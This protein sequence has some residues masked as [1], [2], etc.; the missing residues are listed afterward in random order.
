MKKGIRSHLGFT[1]IE[2]LVVV[3][4][5]G[6]LAAVA[7]PKY[8]GA[9]E[10]S[11]VTEALINLKNA[12]NAFILRYLEDPNAPFSA[13]DI[14]EFQGGEWIEGDRYW[15]DKFHYDFSDFS[16]GVVAMRGTCERNGNN[17]SCNDLYL[18]SL[19][20]PQMGEENW[21]TKKDCETYTDIGYKICKGLESQGFRM[22]DSR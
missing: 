10:K 2:L 9:V 17:T 21:E 3:L 5:I 11:R 14:L 13:E 18:L 22:Y 15:T 8:Q 4:I 6:I 20:T 19:G 16:N 1:L 7:L 12:Q